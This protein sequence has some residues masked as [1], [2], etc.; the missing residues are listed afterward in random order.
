MKILWLLAFLPVLLIK[1]ATI[2]TGL[3]RIRSAKYGTYWDL[4]GTI[5]SCT[6]PSNVFMAKFLG[7]IFQTFT[8]TS[9]P[10][11]FYTITSY[12]NGKGVAV[13]ESSKPTETIFLTNSDRESLNQQFAFVARGVNTYIIK[14][15][16]LFKEAIQP[17]ATEGG[18][19]F[20]ENKDCV[21]PQQHFV[22]EEIP[23]WLKVGNR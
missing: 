3:Y 10:N 14:P 18:D 12:Y 19:I 21:T 6:N 5:I 9:L 16:I 7:D 23:E 1:A 20:L 8:V 4:C 11:G 2:P 15:R 22:L 17:A 13:A